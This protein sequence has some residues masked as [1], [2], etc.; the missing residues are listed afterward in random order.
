MPFDH[1]QQHTKTMAGS[2]ARKPVLFDFGLDGVMKKVRK[3]VMVSK[4]TKLANKLNARIKQGNTQHLQDVLS[5]H[6]I[7]E[8]VQV[9]LLGAHQSC[10]LS[11]IKIEAPR[12]PF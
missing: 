3:G 9:Q 1:N 7:R 11:T 5:L 12:H 2:D 8:I 6:Q 4:D 10:R